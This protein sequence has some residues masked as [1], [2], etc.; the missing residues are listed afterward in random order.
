MRANAC[1]W[2]AGRPRTMDDE[3]EQ[4]LR[5]AEEPELTA[6][7]RVTAQ[8][9]KRRATASS[10]ESKETEKEADRVRKRLSYNEAVALCFC[11][12]A[13][14]R[15]RGVSSGSSAWHRGCSGSSAMRTCNCAKCTRCTYVYLVIVSKRTGWVSII[16]V[17]IV[18]LA[19]A[20]VTT[21]TLL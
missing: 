19:T 11:F 9:Q 5:Q 15:S 3:P 7:E 20:A 8:K 4:P 2:L 21:S 17:Q 12:H 18:C 16:D 14:A 6:L 13:V 10:Q 1:T